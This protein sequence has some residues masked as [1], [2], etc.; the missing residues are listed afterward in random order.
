M[1]QPTSL[2]GLHRHKSCSRSGGQRIGQSA[3]TVP[4][5]L[6][7]LRRSEGMGGGG[8]RPT[9]F[10]SGSSVDVGES[11]GR[12]LA[13]AT[14]RSSGRSS[15]SPPGRCRPDR[16]QWSAPRVACTRCLLGSSGSAAP[17]SAAGLVPGARD[18]SAPVAAAVRR[19]VRPPELRPSPGNEGA[20]PTAPQRTRD[21]RLVARQPRS[22]ATLR[23]GDV[24]STA[25][26]QHGRDEASAHPPSTAACAPRP[27]TWTTKHLIDSDRPSPPGSRQ[28]F[29]V[30][31]GRA[32]AFRDI[33]ELPTTLAR[34]AGVSAAAGR[35]AP[36]CAPGRT[37]NTW[38][39]GE[40]SGSRT[41]RR[42]AGCVR[43]RARG[44]K[45]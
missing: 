43:R 6:A 32:G 12:A 42:A 29:V 20:M 39:R 38:G 15:L 44:R 21:D 1:C 34:Y 13:R 8:G 17:I 23:S 45:V 4:V 10:A 2:V 37:R 41:S 27:R 25:C 16:L 35:S 3:G 18:R 26:R 5:R 19:R 14:C 31:R 24:A 33:H 36:G 40:V 30:S 11:S 9:C 28:P 7:Q 22:P